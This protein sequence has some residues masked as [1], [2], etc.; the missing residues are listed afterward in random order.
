MVRIG[1]HPLGIGLYLFDYKAEFRDEYGQGRQFG[2]MADEAE[3]VMP[4]AVQINES[5]YKAV[6]LGMLGIRRSVH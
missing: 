6:D 5:G 4:A 3:I 2:V 1:W